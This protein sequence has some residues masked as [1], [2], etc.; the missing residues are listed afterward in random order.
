V[1]CGRSTI[2]VHISFFGV[3]PYIV[4]PYVRVR[5]VPSPWPGP[6]P[7]SSFWPAPPPRRPGNREGRGDGSEGWCLT[8]VPREG[9]PRKGRVYAYVYRPCS[10]IRTHHF[11][12][13]GV[14]TLNN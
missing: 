2:N 12:G 4:C 14:R 8:D 6:P 5:P 11:E 7:P 3:C 9:F 1:V 10:H 13:C